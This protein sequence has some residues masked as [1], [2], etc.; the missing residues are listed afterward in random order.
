MKEKIVAIGALITA[1]FA[2]VCCLGP[3]VLVGLGLGGA[4]LAAGIA[5]YRP[6][7]LGVTAILI[8]IAFYLAYCKRE[9]VCKNGTCQLKSGSRK[10]KAVLWVVLFVVVAIGTFPNWSGWFGSKQVLVISADSQKV[11][12]AIS[13]MTCTGC[14]ISIEKSLRKVTGIQFASVDFDKSEAVVQMERGRIKPEEL[15]KAVQSAGHYAAR[16]KEN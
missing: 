11:R 1:G 13:G 5:K 3:I 6:I 2:S 7:F 14:A 10:M 4:G 15:F 16:I 12:L 8:G 9:V